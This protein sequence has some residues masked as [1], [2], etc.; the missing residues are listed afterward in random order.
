LPLALIQTNEHFD[1]VQFFGAT[2]CG[3]ANSVIPT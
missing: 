3:L 1:F 2:R